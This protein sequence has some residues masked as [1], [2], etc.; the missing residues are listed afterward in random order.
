MN[1]RHEDKRE[2]SVHHDENESDLGGEFIN[3]G[4]KSTHYSTPKLGKNKGN[5]YSSGYSH[6]ERHDSINEGNQT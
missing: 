6:R 1:R 5:V 2:Q 3:Y 4:R